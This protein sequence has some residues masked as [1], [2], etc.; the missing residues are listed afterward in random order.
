[1]DPPTFNH[2]D[3]LRDKFALYKRYGVIGCLEGTMSDKIETWVAVVG[4]L[5]LAVILGAEGLAVM[6]TYP[7]SVS[8]EYQGSSTKLIVWTYQ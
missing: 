2:S 7:D 3:A 6:G 1:M 4:F 5:L 8:R